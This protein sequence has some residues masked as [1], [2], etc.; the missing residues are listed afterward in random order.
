[1]SDE[2]TYS[3]P[4]EDEFMRTLLLLLEKKNE[5]D[6]IMLLSEAS[7]SIAPS[8]SFSRH[9]WNAMYTEVHFR[10]PVD[11]YHELSED[12]LIRLIKICD[13]VMPKNVGYDVMNVEFIPTVSTPAKSSSL[14]ADLKE[15]SRSLDA[16]GSQFRLPKDLIAIGSEMSE[17]YLYLYAVENYL[18]LF[19]ETVGKAQYGDDY[20][21]QLTIPTSVTKNINGRKKKEAKN[22]WLRIRGYSDLYYLDFKDLGA[23]IGNN[24]SLFKSHFPD[25]AWI[26]SKIDELGDIRNLVAHNSYLGDHEREV[27]RIYF[28]SIVRQI[29]STVY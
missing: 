20:F 8:S 19:I 11:A 26:S 12:E 4:S 1:M 28:K 21:D 10:V 17:A 16:V 24:W 25:Q 2:F 27:I 14:E 5:L 29:T 18:R 13:I 15:I 9:R 6:L 3:S 7:C 22:Q 23:I